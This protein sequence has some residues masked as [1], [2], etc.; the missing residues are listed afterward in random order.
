MDDIK[1]LVSEIVWNKKAYEDIISQALFTNTEYGE[2]CNLAY[3]LEVGYED[4]ILNKEDKEMIYEMFVNILKG[5]RS[6]RINDYE[7]HHLMIT[8][9][10]EQEETLLV[11]KI[12]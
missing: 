7:E 8:T 3:L 5:I 9:D 1:R 11:K 4:P 6:I 10:P 12:K 2:R